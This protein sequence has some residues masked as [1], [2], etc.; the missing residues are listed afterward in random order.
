MS[1]DL[2]AAPAQD[3][4]PTE[5]PIAHT[6]ADQAV[7]SGDVAAFKEARAAE[8]L[9]TPKAPAPKAEAKA[10][11]PAERTISK[12]QQAINDYERRIAAQ[13]AELARLRTA[14][15]E[16][17]PPTE[18]NADTPAETFASWDDYATQ[19]PDHSYDDYRDAREDWRIARREQQQ[20]ETMRQQAR[21]QADTERVSAFT[22][23]L[24]AH[25]AAEPGFLET[26]SPTVLNL[27]T[28]SQALAA[29]DTPSALNAVAEEIV[30]SPVSPLLMRHF[31]DHPEDLSRMARL[32]PRDLLRDM[33]KLEAALERSTETRSPKPLSR[34][35]SPTTP[36]GTRTA[37]AVNDADA[38]VASGNVAAFKAARLRERLATAQR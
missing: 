16:R 17:T 5:A 10:A 31:S 26:I 19:H 12:R 38:A 2:V 7:A 28:F 21:A 3:T 8:R 14:R 36:L 13:E 15:P 37:D 9:S 11:E 6:A 24:S 22:S 35:P 23:R 1:D 4:S 33:G 32:S 30:A 25:V 27:R 29:G 34:M 18:T 20:Q